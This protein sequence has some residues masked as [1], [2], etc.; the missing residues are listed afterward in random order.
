MCC[1]AALPTELLTHI[2]SVREN[3][4]AAMFFPPRCISISF[5]IAW[6]RMRRSNKEITLR[7]VITHIQAV[8][9]EMRDMGQ[10][11][12]N[13]MKNMEQRLLNRMGAGRG[14]YSTFRGW[15]VREPSFV[16]V[17]MTMG[18]SSNQPTVFGCTSRAMVRP[19]RM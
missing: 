15:A 18:K 14:N 17:R 7:D 9:N 5:T 10:R 8:R 1:G 3:S 19:W 16:G 2:S 4:T 13:D 6:L 12:Q 11:L